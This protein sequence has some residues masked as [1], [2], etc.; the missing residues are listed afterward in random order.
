MTQ[1]RLAVP[2]TDGELFDEIQRGDIL[3]HLPYESFV[4]SVETYRPGRG[5][6]P[7]RDR[8]QDDGLPHER[9]V[10]ARSR[11]DRGSGQ[12]QADGVPRRAESSLRRAAEHRVVARARAIRSPRRLRLPDAE[13]PREDDARRPARRR[14]AAALRP[15]RHRQLP[16]ADGARLRG[17]R[18]VHD[19]REHRRRCRRPLQLP[20]RVR[21]AAAVPQA[22]GRAVHAPHEA[23]RRDQIGFAGREGGEERAHP[24]QSQRTHRREGDRR[25]LRRFFGA[26][27]RSTSSPD[28]SARSAPA[29][30]GSAR[31]SA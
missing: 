16:R 14:R 7:G 31:T 9:R 20:D 2:T 27:P 11:P 29:S 26:G 19:R 18:A 4:T 1:P 13:D 28:R 25:A 3:V 15:R 30:K 8:D 6:R 23:G 17:L 24:H 21:A 22:A 12:R 5:P 10:A